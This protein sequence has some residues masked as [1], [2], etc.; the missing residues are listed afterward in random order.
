MYKIEISTGSEKVL[1][2]LT[3]IIDLKF[4]PSYVVIHRVVHK[5]DSF[6]NTTVLH[7]KN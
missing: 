7:R 2:F 6:Q 4:Q 1:G 3:F 5:S